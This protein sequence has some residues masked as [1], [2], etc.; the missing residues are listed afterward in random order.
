MAHTFTAHSE[1]VEGQYTVALLVEGRDRF[2]VVYGEQRKTGL[3]Y[4][5]AAREYGECL[6]HSLQ[7]AGQLADA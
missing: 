7:C 5:A 2:A 4:A 1:T 3:S 6:M